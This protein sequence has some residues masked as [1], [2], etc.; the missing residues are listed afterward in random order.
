[1]PAIRRRNAQ[2]ANNL[3]LPNS[4]NRHYAAAGHRQLERDKPIAD[5]VKLIRRI[6]FAKTWERHREATIV[7]R[8]CAVTIGL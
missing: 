8:N 1:V 5:Y 3:G 6:P 4:L 7:H 2:P